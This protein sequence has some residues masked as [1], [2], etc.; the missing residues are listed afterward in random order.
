MDHNSGSTDLSNAKYIV[1]LIQIDGGKHM[2]HGWPEDQDELIIGRSDS[3]DV[4]VPDSN[5]SRRHCS[6]S[7]RP[8][9]AFLVV[10][11]DSTNGTWYEGGQVTEQEITTDHKIQI[12][13]YLLKVNQVQWS[14]VE[15]RETPEHRDPPT[16]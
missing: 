15:D 5:V 6:I 9:D 8:D 1:T 7:E 3:C 13:K 11:L 2:R 16:F 14:N 12:G 10:D 4:T